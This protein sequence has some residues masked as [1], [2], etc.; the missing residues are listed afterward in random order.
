MVLLGYSYCRSYV[1]YM[2]LEKA[3]FKKGCE[4][5]ELTYVGSI[6]FSLQQRENIGFYYFFNFTEIY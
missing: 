1:L 2:G 5:V 6:F 3:C 4:L